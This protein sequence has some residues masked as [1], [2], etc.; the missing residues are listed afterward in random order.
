MG[1]FN[2]GNRKDNKKSLTR[3]FNFIDSFSLNSFESL[4]LLIN[5]QYRQQINVTYND[6]KRHGGKVKYFECPDCK[7]RARFLY[8]KNN[9]LSCRVCHDLTYESSQCKNHFNSLAK[10]FAESGMDLK[11]A[12]WMFR[13]RKHKFF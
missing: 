6:R 9:R 3:D 12:K 13:P 1:N 8:V 5:S 7:L 10:T 11:F 4:P 2:S